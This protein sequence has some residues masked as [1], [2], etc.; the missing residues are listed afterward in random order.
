L[1]VLNLMS[2]VA[3]RPVPHPLLMKIFWFTEAQQR[4]SS[5]RGVHNIEISTA[6]RMAFK[7]RIWYFVKCNWWVFQM[8]SQ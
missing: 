6:C 5:R 2:S 1:L 3:V 7:R 8:H 4:F